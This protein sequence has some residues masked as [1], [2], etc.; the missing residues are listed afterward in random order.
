MTERDRQRM[1]ARASEQRLRDGCAD[2]LEDL[3]EVHRQQLDAAAS[4]GD[5]R[6]CVSYRRAQGRERLTDRAARAESGRRMM[7]RRLH[8]SRRYRARQRARQTEETRDAG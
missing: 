6:T 7:E 8:E 1:Q 2:L 3:A 5:R 4:R